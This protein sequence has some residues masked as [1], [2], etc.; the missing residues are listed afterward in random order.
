M[1]GAVIVRLGGAAATSAMGAASGSFLQLPLMPLGVT[2]M[3]VV[4]MVVVVSAP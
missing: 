2:T 4:V 3:V 1:T